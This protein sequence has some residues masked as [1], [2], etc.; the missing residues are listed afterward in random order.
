[1]RTAFII[2]ILLTLSTGRL[3]AEP[4]GEYWGTAEEEAK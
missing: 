1:M 2:A 3:F 4:L